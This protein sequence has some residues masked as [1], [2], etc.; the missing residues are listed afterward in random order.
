[1]VL[2]LYILAHFAQHSTNEAPLALLKYE[3]PG[4]AVFS[5]NNSNYDSDAPI[6]RVT[7]TLIKVTQTTLDC[8]IIF[9]LPR[10][11]IDVQAYSWN[12]YW[13]SINDVAQP[14]PKICYSKVL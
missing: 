13:N 6:A 14:T 5:A 9:C 3:G 1:M 11:N 12:K 2:Q 7:K 4:N 10:T 8:P